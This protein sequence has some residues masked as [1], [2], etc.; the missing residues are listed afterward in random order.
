MWPPPYPWGP[1]T[2]QTWIELAVDACILMWATMTLLLRMF[3]PY[4]ILIPYCRTILPPRSW[5]EQLCMCT[6]WGWFHFNMTNHGT[7][8]FEKIEY[9]LPKYFIVNSW[10]SFMDR[11]SYISLSWQRLKWHQTPVFNVIFERASVKKLLY[12]NLIRH[13]SRENW[14]YLTP[15]KR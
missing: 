1:W 10:S 6:T 8:A 7:R 3:F 2:E 9:I 12:S 4:K 5:F 15:V 11:Y 13:I 14:F